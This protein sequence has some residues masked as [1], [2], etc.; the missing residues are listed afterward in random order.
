MAKQTYLGVVNKVLTRLRITNVATVTENT[1]STLIGQFVNDAMREVEDA[2]DWTRLETTINVSLVVGDTQYTLTGAGERFRIPD[3]AELIWNDS[4]ELYMQPRPIEYI[5]EMNRQ[6][7]VTNNTPMFYAFDGEDSSGDPTFSVTPPASET[8]TLNVDVI[9]PTAELTDDADTINVNW[10]P[11]YL[12][13]YAMAVS[14][15]GEDGGNNYSEVDLLADRALQDAIAQDVA[16]Q[17]ER[18]IMRVV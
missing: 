12:R 16:L 3:P 14:E 10:Y 7:G 13:A 11:I 4:Q 1:Y 2:W 17:R 6:S 15:R 5:R 8:D 18:L 9:V